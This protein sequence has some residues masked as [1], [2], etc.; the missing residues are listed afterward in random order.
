MT[1]LMDYIYIYKY[2]YIYTYIYI[3]IFYSCF[4]YFYVFINF[5]GDIFKIIVRRYWVALEIALYKFSIFFFIT[6]INFHK[7]QLRLDVFSMKQTYIY[8][9]IFFKLQCLGSIRNG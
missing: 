8:T 9:Y 5:I 2:T 3:Q 4:R 7:H 1:F 6:D